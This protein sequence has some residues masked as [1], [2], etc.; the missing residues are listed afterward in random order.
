MQTC[1]RRS[2]SCAMNARKPRRPTRQ[3]CDSSRDRDSDGLPFR[4]RFHVGDLTPAVSVPTRRDAKRA[5]RERALRSKRPTFP[6]PRR[7]RRDAR[8]PGARAPPAARTAPQPQIPAASTRA[9]RSRCGPCAFSREKKK[10]KVFSRRRRSQ[11]RD[12]RRARP[13][14]SSRLDA[15][16]RR[17]AMV[18]ALRSLSTGV[19]AREDLPR[20]LTA[21][22]KPLSANPAG[23]R[24]SG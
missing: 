20:R 10:G 2:R 19:A 12:E 13:R 4:A 6:T 16:R 3:R 5:P 15:N 22:E 17:L 18:D 24:G 14:R 1:S 21:R 9:G 23:S 8:V 7:F 11:W